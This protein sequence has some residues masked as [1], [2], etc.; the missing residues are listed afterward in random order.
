MIHGYFDE[1]GA[2]LLDCL[3]SIPELDI[4][5]QPVTMLVSTGSRYSTLHP[6]QAAK[7]G[8]TQDQLHA[9]GF[10]TRP[11]N[12]SL[13]F[14]D[15][16]ANANTPV[17]C[18]INRLT[19]ALPANRYSGNPSVLGMDVIAQMDLHYEPSSNTLTLSNPAAAR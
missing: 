16:N 8:I 17:P 2:P 18:S 11:F 7:L 5:N 3:I 4:D 6:D 9:Q 13:S 12:A 1:H 14:H 15:D 19:V 10:Q